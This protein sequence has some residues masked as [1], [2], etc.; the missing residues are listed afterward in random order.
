MFRGCKVSG[1]P[2]YVL[3]LRSRR[4][5]GVNQ[6]KNGGECKVEK[7]TPSRRGVMNNSSNSG[8]VQWGTM[9][10]TKLPDCKIIKQRMK[11]RGATELG[12]E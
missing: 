3:E 2:E 8:N 12:K 7:A 4:C 1:L 6:A 5:V 9:N 10:S 11:S